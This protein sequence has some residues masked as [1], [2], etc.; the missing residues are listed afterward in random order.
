MSGKYDGSLVYD[1]KI[2][3]DGFERGFG[4]MKNKAKVSSVEI[5]KSL[6]DTRDTL[7]SFNK[8]A[9][10]L[11]L[12]TAA[13]GAGVLS[14]GIRYNAQMEQY[15]AGF[16][17][18]LGNAEKAQK[19]MSD[20]KGF[21]A[22]TPFEL[23]DLANASTTLLAFGEDVNQLM[24]DLK[25]LGDIS[26]GN[27]EK[28][29]GLA[30]VFGQV[31][32][33]GRLMGQDLL[34]M[35]N[36][37]FNPLQIISEKTGK[38]VAT[39]KDE[40][41]KGQIT[42]E[43]VADAM[44][45]ATSEGGQFYNAMQTQAKTLSGQW[46]TLKDNITALTGEMSEDISK[47]LTTTVLPD[48]IDKVELLNQMWEDGR[49]Q[50]YIGTATAA[51]AAFGTAIVGLNA[52]LFINDLIQIKK[53]V[54]G[55]TAATKAGTAA[56]KLMNA[57]LLKNPYTLALTAVVALTA[58]IVTYA[59]T[60][61]SALSDIR[62]SYEDAVEAE[63]KAIVTEKAQAEQAIILKN[64]LLELEKQTKNGTHSDEQATKLKKE[65]SAVAEQLAEFIPEITNAIYDEN[66]AID[67]QVTKVEQLTQAYYDL[68]TAKALANAYQGKIDAAV[69]AKV[70]IQ[71]EIDALD[72]S[73]KYITQETIKWDKND[74]YA[75]KKRKI[76]IVN[77]PK[78]QALLDEQEKFD[79]EISKWQKKQASE[80]IKI[81]DISS[82]D[83]RDKLD[84]GGGLTGGSSGTSSGTK[85]QG[86]T[87]D[88][89]LRKLK[90]SL[91]MAEITEEEYYNDLEKLRDTYLK[92]GTEEW[93]QYTEDI[94]AF[95][96]KQAEAARD[97]EFRDLK[98]SLAMEEITEAEYYSKLE[99]LRD[100]YFE[101][102]S[103]D[104]QQ[105]TEEI[106]GYSKKTVEDFVDKLEDAQSEAE[107]T[108]EELRDKQKRISDNLMSDKSPVE[109]GTIDGQAF[110]NLANYDVENYK[111]EKYN[112][113]LNELFE[114][115]PDLPRSVLEELQGMDIDRGMKYVEAL[116]RASDSQYASFVK[117]R[118]LEAEKSSLIS[119]RLTEDEVEETKKILEDKFGQLPEDF[120][121]IGEDSI[122]QFGQGFLEGLGV[123]M[124]IIREQI[125]AEMST[126]MPVAVGFA[127]AGGDI[128]SVVNNYQNSYNVGSSKQTITEQLS[129]LANFEIME[130]MRGIK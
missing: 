86:G 88:E 130:R 21:A 52:A 76:E 123:M 102:G 27:S 98:H 109:Y 58:G 117:G 2:N 26:L 89:E 113:M 50:D 6:E 8:T 20:L 4:Q 65:F 36:Q 125:T 73:D 17:T 44:K 61:K 104:W 66:G 49:L 10:K 78:Y 33:Q 103:D 106:Y 28:F 59:A 111:L 91:A 60:H 87:L 25:M 37:G 11:V 72:Y 112:K 120:F 56:Q 101:E 63:E 116:M 9:K 108:M 121:Q 70:D 97:K 81:Q 100:K 68:V 15:N 85:K 13:I 75:P 107:K 114:K 110:V 118:N 64:R 18:M 126:L 67:I 92:E 46:S 40:M 32:S 29:K 94:Y 122:E 48:L 93:Q 95:K 96:K 119:S 128:S 35:I 80:L 124:Q 71:D 84:S 105:Y 51:L 53:G 79:N 22:E 38:S 57:E 83:K 12:G 34:Q 74:V 54:E 24:P 99:E 1:T 19:L 7:E 127:S 47:K 41:S 55:F 82:D 129:S 14:L 23:T 115:R 3:T 42:F 31:Q 39:L 5:K 90:H 77:T 30:L 62:K 16:T 45:T 43:M 69:K